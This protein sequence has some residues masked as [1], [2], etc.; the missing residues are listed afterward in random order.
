MRAACDTC[1]ATG[2]CG[3]GGPPL[4]QYTSYPLSVRMV[5]QSTKLSYYTH[6]PL[7]T[8]KV[9]PKRLG[10]LEQESALSQQ[11][12]EKTEN[13]IIIKRILEV[14]APVGSSQVLMLLAAAVAVACCII[15]IGGQMSTRP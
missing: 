4:L 11:K 13:T 3:G 7:Q 6:S 12:T 8:A 15:A 10:Q 1:K 2:G 14:R 9:K 5:C